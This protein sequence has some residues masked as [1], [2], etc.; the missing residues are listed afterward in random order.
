MAKGNVLL[1]TQ[2]EGLG[3]GEEG[4]HPTLTLRTPTPERK[5]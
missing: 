3:R 1:L 2:A 5:D 4:A